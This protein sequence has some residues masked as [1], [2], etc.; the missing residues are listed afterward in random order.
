MSNDSACLEVSISL[1]VINII[2]Y[3]GRRVLID[4]FYFPIYGFGK[5]AEMN[6]AGHFR[7]SRSTEH[8][9]N[10]INIMYGNYGL[11]V[12]IIRIC[13]K[14]HICKRSR[15]FY[16]ALSVVKSQTTTHKK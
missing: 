9:F 12:Y 15:S 14:P 5:I 6:H 2:V 16:S 1:I 4:E 13:S 10:Y 3:V 8:N 7:A 11:F